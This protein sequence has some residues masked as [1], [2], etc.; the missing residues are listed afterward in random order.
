MANNKWRRCICPWLDIIKITVFEAGIAVPISWMKVFTKMFK[1]LAHTIILD[2]I[3]PW[4]LLH[5]RVTW[6]PLFSWFLSYFCTDSGT[7]WLFPCA[8]NLY[9]LLCILVSITMHP[10]VETWWN[11][12]FQKAES[13]KSPYF[14]LP[15]CCT[16]KSVTTRYTDLMLLSPFKMSQ[17]P[18]SHLSSGLWFLYLESRTCGCSSRSLA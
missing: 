14:Y 6:W 11:K 15:S 10:W 13:L 1:F 8:P 12:I 16:S 7:A 5:G 18:L 17:V 3:C 2:Y 9:Q 4:H